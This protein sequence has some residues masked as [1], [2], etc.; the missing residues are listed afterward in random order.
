MDT[1][2]RILRTAL[3]LFIERG[4]VEVSVNDLIKEVG[5]AK[6]GF[7][8][9]FKSKDELIGEIIE[10]FIIPYLD[11]LIRSVDKSVGSPTKRLQN[12]FKVPTDIEKNLRTDLDVNKFNNRALIILIVEAIKKYEVMTN[13][14]IQFSNELLMKVEAVI[15]EGKSLGEFSSNSDSKST[16]WY[17]ISV[18]QG[19]IALWIMNPEIDIQ[20]LFENNYKCVWQ[21]ISKSGKYNK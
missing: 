4:F 17:V 5:I 21:S 3:K 11:E 1:K 10:K 18:I 16:A 14:V 8:H 9:H 7:Y 20:M 12:L 2:D 6:G 19:A 13:Y 15:E